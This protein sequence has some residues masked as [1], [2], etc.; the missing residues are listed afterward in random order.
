VVCGLITEATIKDWRLKDVHDMRMGIGREERA[1]FCR[2]MRMEKE[3]FFWG[4][5]VRY[6]SEIAFE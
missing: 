5:W 6:A 3:R 4:S 2:A 1:F